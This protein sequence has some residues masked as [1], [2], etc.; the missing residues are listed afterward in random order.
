M[1]D[2]A[3]AASLH[4]NNAFGTDSAELVLRLA[5]LSN[6][7]ASIQEGA[8]AHGGAGTLLAATSVVNSFNKLWNR[9]PEIA[10]GS[11][12]EFLGGLVD[13][14]SIT[15]GVASLVR[16]GGAEVFLATA[17][18]IATGLEFLLDFKW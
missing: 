3:N 15:L 18:S 2:A 5:S 17:S 9:M 16:I 7:I 1:N 4:L 8:S 13:V 6:D 10:D 14:A 12:P 11:V